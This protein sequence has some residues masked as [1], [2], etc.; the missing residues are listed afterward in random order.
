MRKQDFCI[1]ENQS[2]DQLPSSHAADQC[3]CFHYTE[4]T[5]PQLRKSHIYS[6]YP[7]SETVQPGLCLT[8]SGIPRTGFTTRPQGYKTFFML[9]S[10]EHEI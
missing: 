5:M 7:S 3:L 9:N 10:A 6:P 8:W 4:S 1:C 2:A